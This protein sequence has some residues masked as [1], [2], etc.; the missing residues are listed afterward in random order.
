MNAIGA[1]QR[2]DNNMKFNRDAMLSLSS[3]P[4]QRLC[5][6]YEASHA[7][8]NTELHALTAPHKLALLCTLIDACFGTAEVTKHMDE[9]A[10]EMASRIAESN[11]NIRDAKLAQKTV[12]E[13]RRQDAIA[14]C[15]AANQAAAELKASKES[16]SP[17]KK[18]NSKSKATG[19]VEE[20]T[21]QQIQ[22]MITE[23]VMLST[24]DVDGVK[25]LPELH[26][27]QPAM[28]LDDDNDNDIYGDVVFVSSTRLKNLHKRDRS[29]ELTRAWNDYESKLQ[30]IEEAY[31]II[32]NA[33]KSGV[34]KD[35]RNAMKKGIRS[36]HRW[37]GKDGK[38]YC[39]PPLRDIYKAVNALDVAAKEESDAV[40]AEKAFIH[41]CIRVEPLGTDRHNSV[42][43]R[44]SGCDDKLF[45]QTVDAKA[46]EHVKA[47][48]QTR[49]S[50]HLV[51]NLFNDHPGIKVL[52][53]CRPTL[54]QYTWGCHETPTSLWALCESLDPTKYENEKLLK[55]AVVARFNVDEPS[56]P[57][58]TTGSEFIGRRV[59]RVFGK[60][61][62]YDV[63]ST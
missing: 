7:L 17:K 23:L 14:A 52:Y 8:E 49:C 6:L 29:M 41:F 24:F 22:D 5:A 57:Y 31:T 50:N 48:S 61:V 34:E 37:V 53:N 51:T 36:G 40:M 54:K 4:L 58:Q 56:I 39:S 63:S 25:D 30:S 46:I 12:S 62:N 10:E 1:A 33:L 35:L 60:K 44:F 45:V 3:D 13:A 2:L 59:T 47:A 32:D 43:W 55:A 28:K 9:N 19:A 27:E 18:S 42:Y 16:K 11:K 15:K 26:V 20:P 38:T 21:I